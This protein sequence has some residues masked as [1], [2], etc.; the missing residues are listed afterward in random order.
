MCSTGMQ[1]LP[2]S[3]VDT[4]W[5]GLF[6]TGLNGTIRERVLVLRASLPNGSPTRFSTIHGALRALG[7]ERE[8]YVEF[9]GVKCCVLVWLSLIYSESQH[10]LVLSWYFP[11]LP[12]GFL[13]V[14]GNV[15]KSQSHKCL[16]YAPRVGPSRRPGLLVPLLRPVH[17]GL[18][19][20]HLRL[21]GRVCAPYMAWAAFP[22]CL[23]ATVPR[24]SRSVQPSGRCFS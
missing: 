11:I 2:A 9:K 17:C 12:R 14:L 3:G 4:D 8:E 19:H 24:P 13:S 6:P 16:S 7:Y 10:F 18:A 1:V 15:Y 20:T 22:Q 5:R 23:N 21:R